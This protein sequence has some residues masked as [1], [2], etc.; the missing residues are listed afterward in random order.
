MTVLDGEGEHRVRNGQA[1]GVPEQPDV[2]AEQQ[3]DAGREPGHG[4][5]QKKRLDD[6]DVLV[7]VR[8]RSVSDGRGL[9]RRP[10]SVDS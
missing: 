10:Q 9:D 6:A 2:H 5:H 7:A 1:L 3:A 4:L 8:R